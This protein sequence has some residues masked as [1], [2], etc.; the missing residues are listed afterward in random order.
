MEVTSFSFAQPGRIH[1]GGG[2]VSLLGA[3]VSGF[4][5]NVLWV[6]GGH[7]VSHPQT[8]D[9]VSACLRQA[10]LFFYEW[11]ISGE[12]SPADV[13]NAVSSFHDRAIDVVLSVGGGSVID[14]GKAIS[15]ML[16]LGIPVTDF[17]EGVGSKKHPGVK[18]PFIA[19]PTT[20]GTGTEA[21]KNAVLSRIGPDGFKK[22]LRHDNFM[23]DVAIVDPSLTLSCPPHLS[24][25]C[26]MDALCQLL[27]S[28]VSTNANAMTDAL[29]RS[30]LRAVRDGLVPACTSGG[31]DIGVRARMSYAALMSGITLANAGLGVVHG[32]A[33]AIGGLFS[34]PHGVVC[35]GLCAACMRATVEKLKAAE[36]SLPLLEKFSRAGM[37]LCGRREPSVEQNCGLLIDKLEELTSLLALPRLGSYG[38]TEADIPAICDRTGNKNNPAKLDKDDL[39][40]ILLS[41]L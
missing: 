24:A 5:K 23:P 1:F 31:A 29:A 12:P 28:Y 18:I 41:A 39:R 6:R 8:Y 35:A 32:F 26:G 17:L 4:G 10:G 33:S 15:A 37:I 13:D 14:A 3:V 22:S 2:T 16:P 21:T 20:A 30:G 38:I 11:E 34:V 19:M 9:A 36:V 27:E 25:A 40:K 7:P